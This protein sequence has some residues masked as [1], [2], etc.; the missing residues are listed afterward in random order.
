MDF[1][2]KQPIELT[3]SELH[4]TCF[5]CNG[6]MDISMKQSTM[7]REKWYHVWCWRKMVG[8]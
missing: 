1:F 3:E 6:E 5:S 4:Q 8:I 7:F 2:K